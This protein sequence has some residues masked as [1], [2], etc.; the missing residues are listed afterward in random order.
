MLSKLIK[1]EFNATARMLL[2]LYL[3][4]IVL[5]IMDRIVLNL[6]IF[7]GVL[8]FVPR[9]ITF[10]YVVSMI[11]IAV[12]T[13]VI[14]ILRFYKNLMTDEGYLMFTLPAKSHQLI[15]SKLV[16][17]FIWS[18]ASVVVILASCFLAFATS[19]RLDL[20]G[21]AFRTAI[22]ELNKAF[23]GNA[24]LFIFEMIVVII[25]GVLNKILTLYVSI[26]V[27]Q[28]FNGHKVIG[29]FVSFVG[30]SFVMQILV[31]ILMVIL[32]LFFRTSINDVN[33]LPQIILPLTFLYTLVTSAIFYW[34][35]NYIF[36]NKLNLE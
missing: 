2:P 18:I 20:V 25:I 31:T 24:A 5:T 26:A 33:I 8:I 6:D 35:T 32:G 14:I 1:H 34:I 13:F 21:E 17:S 36:K 28:L 16:V 7:K 29:A 22:A 30:I 12:V 9:F 10:A 11:A 3:V 15:D 27:G 4:L 19:S 23:D